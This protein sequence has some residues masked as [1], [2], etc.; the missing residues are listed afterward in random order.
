LAREREGAARVAIARLEPGSPRYQ[1]ARRDLEDA[2]QQQ[3]EL[4]QLRP[5]TPKNAPLRDTELADK[6]VRHDTQY[7]TVVD[8]IRIACMNVEADLAAELAP[9][10][11]RPAEAKK[12]LGNLF[13]APGRIVVRDSTVRVELSPAATPTERTA[14]AELLVVVNRW[15]LT[16]PG[17]E[18][19]RRLRF[20]IQPEL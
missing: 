12:T 1:K 19:R 11:P 7:K 13:A 17:D 18:R 10:L 9:L 4:E 6:L 3:V 2:T 5:S 8:T 15:N 20:S 16:L 14:F